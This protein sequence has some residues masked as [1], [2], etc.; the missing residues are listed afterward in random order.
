MNEVKNPNDYDEI[1]YCGYGE[2]LIRLN[3]ILE[4]AK[5]FKAKGIR[6]RINTNGHGNMIHNRNIVPE[7]A[8]YIDTISIS[9]NTDTADKYDKLCQSQFAQSVSIYDEMK[10]FILE[11][12]KHIPKVVVTAVDAPSVDIEQCK[13]IAKEL[14]VDFKQRT[15]GIVG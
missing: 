1:V 5:I 8:R 4:S 10:K 2:P 12:K 3:L 15:Y 14:A 9:L 6:L 11:C 7:L 13:N